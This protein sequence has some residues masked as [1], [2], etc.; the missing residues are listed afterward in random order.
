VDYISFNEG[1]DKIFTEKGLEKD[2][3]KRLEE[4]KAPS[5]LDP[6]DVLNNAEEKLLDECLT[7]VGTDVKYRRLLLKPFFQDKDKSNSGFIQNTRFK[8]ILD[9]M[10]IFVSEEEFQ[11]ICKRFQAKAANEINYVEFDYVLRFYSGD[12]QPF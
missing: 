9:T 1:I 4:F 3:T 6:K 12:H 11:T 5:I 10:K 7:R 8:S 2:P